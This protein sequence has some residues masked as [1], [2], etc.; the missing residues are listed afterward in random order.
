MYAARFPWT[1]FAA[2]PVQ[3][4]GAGSS[5]KLRGG[6]QRNK[7]LTGHSPNRR[8]PARRRASVGGDD[9]RTT[10]ERGA[11]IKARAEPDSPS[12]GVFAARPTDQE[13]L[14]RCFDTR[15]SSCFCARSRRALP[16][17]RERKRR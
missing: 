6:G 5:G 17:R 13:E 10:L 8:E 2:R 15:Q 11:R 4:S 9:K 3:I 1:G 14:Q 12:R 16:R 7:T